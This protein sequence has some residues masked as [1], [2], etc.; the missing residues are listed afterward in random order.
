MQDNQQP[1]S[2]GYDVTKLQ[3]GSVRQL[4]PEIALACDFGEASY[5]SS[6]FMRISLRKS[7]PCLLSKVKRP[8]SLLLDSYEVVPLMEA[9][10][11]RDCV[12]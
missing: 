1:K 8:K 6:S 4:R 9:E 11:R 7:G 12:G 10:F 2:D 5:K 3:E